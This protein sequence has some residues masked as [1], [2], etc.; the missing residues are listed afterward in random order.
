MA[1]TKSRETRQSQSITGRDG[2][3][4]AKAFAYA[5]EMIESPAERWQEWSDCQDMKSIFEAL[6]SKPL[7]EDVTDS[8][9]FHLNGAGR[10]VA[11]QKN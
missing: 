7:R 6:F 11:E 1:T 10:E 8:A 3:I 4:A 2:Y 9:R 5:I